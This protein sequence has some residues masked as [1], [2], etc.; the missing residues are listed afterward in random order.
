MAGCRDDSIKNCDIAV[1]REL[2]VN[3]TPEKV[4]IAL[5]EDKALVE[6]HHEKGEHEF[7][8]GDIYLGKVNKIASSLN[9]AFVDVGYLKDAF[10]HYTDLSPQFRTLDKILKSKK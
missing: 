5:L 7:T 4:D 10:L 8:A 1:N 9:A 3:C 2:I 6:I